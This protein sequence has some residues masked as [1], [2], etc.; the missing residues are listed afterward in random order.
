MGVG[1][2]SGFREKT[3]LCTKAQRRVSPGRFYRWFLGVNVP[4]AFL[5]AM[6]VVWHNSVV[7]VVEP[8]HLILRGVVALVAFAVGG[9]IF[10]RKVIGPA[11]AGVQNENRAKD[12]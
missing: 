6:F 4:I 1:V 10:W 9:Y 11:A 7:E 8:R 3:S 5:L 12:V 2:N